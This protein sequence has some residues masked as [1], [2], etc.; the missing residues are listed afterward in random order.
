MGTTIC[1][2][3][4]RKLPRNHSIQTAPAVASRYATS[5]I[6]V[7]MTPDQMNTSNGFE[8]NRIRLP[9]MMIAAAPQIVPSARTGVPV[10]ECTT[11]RPWAP[12][13]SRLSA[14]RTRVAPTTQARMQANAE[15][16]VPS[17]MTSPIQLAT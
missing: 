10:R 1:H 9:M 11:P 17:V 8:V 4:T 16:A 15:T 3:G 7:P 2:S 12:K 13:P 6:R 14:Y 5:R